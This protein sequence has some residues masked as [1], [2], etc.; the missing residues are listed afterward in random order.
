MADD[1][2][3]LIYEKNGAELEAPEE[4]ELKASNVT[5]DPI[6]SG[7]IATDVKAGI[8]EIS[9]TVST[10]ASP[11]FSFGRASN[12]NAGTFLNVEGVPSNKAGRWVYINNAIVTKVFVS[13]ELSTTF[14]LEV[15]YHTGNGTGL[16]SIGSVT[17]TAAYGDSFDVSF[18]VPTDSQ[19]ALRVSAGSARNMVAGLELQGTN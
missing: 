9:Q 2:K 19:L 12:V 6:D 18:A 5:Y 1:T 16:T 3:V 7:L 10:S 4:L 13:N 14:T 15:L 8:D 11:G 17:V